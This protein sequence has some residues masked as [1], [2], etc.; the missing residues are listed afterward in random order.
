M[1]SSPTMSELA[2]PSDDLRH[3]PSD[4][5]RSA[6]SV[7]KPSRA[8]RPTD[9]VDSRSAMSRMT[10]E[11]RDRLQA[12][13][14]STRPKRAFQI[15]ISLLP[16]DHSR[17]EDFKA[18]LYPARSAHT[19]ETDSIEASGTAGSAGNGFDS[20]STQRGASIPTEELDAF[21]STLI[22]DP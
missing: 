6:E 16:L 7:D 21:A 14:D 11:Q 15:G 18:L 1:G 8:T 17:W 3:H 5:T 9:T 20:S 22:S 4:G 2:L 13:F 19:R 10:T 12:F